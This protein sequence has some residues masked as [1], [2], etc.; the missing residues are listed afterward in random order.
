MKKLLK[1]ALS[2][3]MTV[4]LTVPMFSMA[5]F[6]AQEPVKLELPVTIELT[7]SV[8]TA[9]EDL[10]VVLAAKD[11]LSPMPE[12]SADGKYSMIMTGS[13]GQKLVTKNFPAMTYEKVG[14]HDYTIHQEPGVKTKGTYDKSIYYVTVTVTNAEN[15]ELATT[16]AVHKDTMDAQPKPGE[17]KFTN[18][19]RSGGGGGGNGGGGGG[20]PSGGGPGAPSTPTETI[21]PFDVPLALPQ[22]GTLWW[23]VPILAI[24]GIGMFLIGMKRRKENEDEEI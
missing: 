4:A 7:G 8:S 17:I 1:G 24:G 5:A 20:T 14:I 19:Y 12:G 21:L 10:T 15:G 18:H 2:I 3:L 6:A 23:L 11:A 22:T 13:A 16:V 9:A